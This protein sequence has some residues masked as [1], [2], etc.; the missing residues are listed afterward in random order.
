MGRAAAGNGEISRNLGL[1]A[2][3]RPFEE[4]Y[5]PVMQQAWRAF[6]GTPGSG[7]GVQIYARDRELVESVV[8]YVAAGW[9]RDEPAVLVATPA[10]LDL[11]REGLEALG[12]DDAELADRG[13]LVWADAEETLS[14]LADEGTLSRRRFDAVIGGLI[15]GVSGPDGRPAR[16]F[17][18][19]VDLL[20]GQGRLD[21]AMAL[22]DLWIDAAD[23]RPF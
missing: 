3:P 17:G 5:L 8:A 20:A 12:W 21:E 15:D 6:L 10:H 4:R 23:R 14:A 1:S 22:E 13:L 19:M 7:H 2:T 9:Q 16:V 11:F 18:E